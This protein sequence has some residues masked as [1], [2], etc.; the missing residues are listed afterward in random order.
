[1]GLDW[2]GVRLGLDWGRRYTEVGLNRGEVRL[3]WD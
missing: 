1:M 2:G 3:G